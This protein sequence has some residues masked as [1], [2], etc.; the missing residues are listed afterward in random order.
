MV[1]YSDIPFSSYML[2]GDE[3]MV[4]FSTV[5]P[6]GENNAIFTMCQLNS[7][8]TVVTKSLRLVE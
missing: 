3:E 7:D 8:G 2:M 4:I 6:E 1:G 5:M